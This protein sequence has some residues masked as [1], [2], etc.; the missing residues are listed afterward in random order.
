MKARYQRP[1][2]VRHESGL[3]NK[4]SRV[5]AMRPLTEIDGV[6]VAALVAEHGSPLFV[7]S[8]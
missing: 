6:P 4:F 5:Q 3:M 1:V 7:F 8:E 2:L